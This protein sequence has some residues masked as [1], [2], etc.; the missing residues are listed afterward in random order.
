MWQEWTR[1]DTSYNKMINPNLASPCGFK[2]VGLNPIFRP[3]HLVKVKNIGSTECLSVETV[4][5]T[6]EALQYSCICGHNLH[7]L[8]WHLFIFYFWSRAPPWPPFNVCHSHMACL[9]LK[10][11]LYLGGFCL[12]IAAEL[13]WTGLLHVCFI[14]FLEGR[15]TR[16]DELMVETQTWTRCDTLHCNATAVDTLQKESSH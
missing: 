7:P 8:S 5:A 4:E 15:E 9:F 6:R 12:H 2:G 10:H 11:I 13:F 16:A 14:Y 3:Q 1:R